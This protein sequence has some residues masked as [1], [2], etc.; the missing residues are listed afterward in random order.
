MGPRAGRT[1]RSAAAARLTTVDRILT[2]V[3][4]DSKTRSDQPT[5][6]PSSTP[7]G[8]GPPTLPDTI[9]PGLPTLSPGTVQMRPGALVDQLEAPAMPTLAPPGGDAVPFAHGPPP[10][11]QAR[12]ELGEE[13][14]RGGM[15]RVV[16]ATDTL[17]GREV[18]LK[19]ALGLD[20][21]ALRRFQ[22]EI[23]I[24]ARLEH[25]SIVPVHDAGSL[26]SGEPYYVM[27]K[28]SGRP[29]ER[30]VATAETV[31][32][33]LALIPHIVASAHA[34]AHAHER[35]I[36][37]RDIKPSNILVGELGETIVIDWGLAKLIGEADD[38]VVDSAIEPT[39]PNRPIP[40]TPIKPGESRSSSAVKSQSR[41]GID[42]I[43]TRAG[44]VFG[45]PGF[46]A[47]EQL[48][49]HP[50]NER[51][52][53][54]AL[55]ATLYHLLSR[56]PPHHAKTADEMM[57][58]AA[59]A[60]PTPIGEL[61][62][63]VPA[64]LS[65]IIDKALAH[66]PED[67]YPD[68][69]ALAEDLQRFLTG[70][71]VASHRYSPREKLARFVR[72]HRV[73]VTVIAIA[74]LALIIGGAIAVTRV[75]GERDRATE[76]ERIAIAEK[77][78]AEDRA[79]ELTLAQAR[80][81]AD[82]N[83]TYALALVRPLT[84]TY[85]REVRTIA[86]AAR[87]HGVAWSMPAAKKLATLEMSRDGLRALAA[88]QDGVIQIYDLPKRSARFVTKLDTAMSAR[89]A[90]DE[91]QIVTWRGTRLV[92]LDERG[93]KLGEVTTPTP[94][95]DLEVVGTTAYWVDT[96]QQLWQ[97]NITGKAPIQVAL[98]E[99]V[100]QLAPSPNGR[101]IALHGVDHLM[102]LDREHPV[103]PPIDITNGKTT[104][105][106][107][108]DDS[109]NLV[110][111]VNESALHIAFRP[112]PQIVQ[113]GYVGQREHIAFTNGLSFTIG[114]TGV[115]LVSRDEGGVRRPID[116]APAGLREAR[117]GTIVAGSRGGL[118][119]LSVRGEHTI[120]IPSGQLDIV[121]ASA[122]S[123]YVIATIEN[124][125]LVWNLDELQPALLA[126]ELPAFADFLDADHVLATFD[127]EARSIELP[128]GTVAPLG[129]IS[130]L[131]SIHGAPGGKRACMIDVGHRARVF[132]KSQL[133][134]VEGD[135]DVCGCI[136]DRQVLVG[137][138]TPG[139]LRFYDLE[140]GKQTPLVSRTT[141]LDMAWS[142]TG[143]AWVAAAF[144][145]RMLWR[146]NPQTG[147]NALA[148]YTGAAP[149]RQLLVR[150]DGTV[151]FAE[152]TAIHAWRPDGNIVV[153][154]HTPKPVVALGEAGE[155]RAIAFTV[156]HGM[157]IVDLDVPDRVEESKIPLDHDRPSMSPETGQIVV[158]DR[159][160]I[161]LLDPIARHKW[162]L[163]MPGWV[164]DHPTISPAGNYVLAR[165]LPSAENPY[166]K[167][168]LLSWS[169][170]VPRNAA[171]TVEWVNRM[172]NAIVDPKNPLGLG[173]Q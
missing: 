129:N 111:L 147:V 164:L 82:K 33:R 163:A 38:P 34:I 161:S 43:K 153:H 155:N 8:Q 13:I 158:P 105:L 64:E 100:T 162:Q 7:G 22:R 1:A 154:A 18:A 4:D 122:R 128:G 132:S 133:V 39:T 66:D 44:I 104:D 61:V 98:D 134:E 32:Q 14:A 72:K 93:K 148:T 146:R 96:K 88:G 27:R 71:L 11:P 6:P 49:G 30:L 106:D 160:G 45:T 86:A 91:H 99:G 28:I 42:I 157:Y 76:A 169:L 75:I 52:D 79:A 115:A 67:R 47:P 123:P 150:A 143:P 54:Y 141:L 173:W 19:E 51:C 131:I 166:L 109:E 55:G 69:R 17:L 24:T 15:G 107:W 87:A 63:G 144:G 40:P 95:V 94:I 172:T 35:G 156:D 74:T 130:E 83:P 135:A 85:W 57:K 3:A 121:E 145:D 92:V 117:G 46:M 140:T 103:D 119:I 151:M 56:K 53:V 149:P 77:Q 170:V 2:K 137:T 29:L 41:A 108:S 9:P 126:D 165:A 60:P 139:T 78:R 68:A 138:R 168:S 12:Y 124:F 10:M 116:G 81:V 113:R 58:A 112:H 110:A 36:V 62:P 89:F 102:V 97:L 84:A 21:E 70:Q 50:V 23:K 125:L 90:D 152:G 16:E 25:P 167:P 114:A 48:R 136:T 73:P 5:L 26:P 20:A 171:D 65:T 101:W 31:A 120:Q 80:S 142:R 118:V 159:G 37:H 127:G 59:V